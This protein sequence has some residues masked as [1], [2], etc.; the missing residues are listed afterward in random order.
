MKH[1]IIGENV[2]E[3]EDPIAVVF[4]DGGIQL[5]PAVSGGCVYAD[6]REKGGTG[7]ALGQEPDLVDPASRGRGLEP[8]VGGSIQILETLMPCPT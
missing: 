8:G 1:K 4:L 6:L 3:G 5:A 2:V 7:R